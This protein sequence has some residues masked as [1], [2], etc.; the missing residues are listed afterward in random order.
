M[1]FG[2]T[3]KD[4]T[5]EQRERWKARGYE[6]FK[7]LKRG[8]RPV[9]DQRVCKRADCSNAGHYAGLC[10]GH[11]GAEVRRRMAEKRRAS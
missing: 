1:G 5:R 10:T 6:P 8:R 11:F 3:Q 4:L 2:G 7:R 9:G